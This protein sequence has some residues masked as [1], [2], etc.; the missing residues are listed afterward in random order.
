MV[1]LVRDVDGVSDV[2]DISSHVAK[3][4]EFH[5]IRLDRAD[6]AVQEQGTLFVCWKPQP[7][8]YS[9]KTANTCKGEPEGKQS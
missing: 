8:R 2:D 5:G 3:T 9:S 4:A 1:P 7:E 6:Q